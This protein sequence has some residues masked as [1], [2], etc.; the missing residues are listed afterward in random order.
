MIK[1][2]HYISIVQ[3]G[4]AFEV[5]TTTYLD[6][7]ILV[8]QSIDCVNVALMWNLLVFFCFVM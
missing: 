7:S 8:H 6:T 2:S 5:G 4:G 1:L 3:P